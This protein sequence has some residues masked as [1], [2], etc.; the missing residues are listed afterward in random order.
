MIL[1]I[2]RHPITI[3]TPELPDPDPAELEVFTGGGPFC[4]AMIVKSFR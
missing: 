2:M 3:P 4:P 1:A